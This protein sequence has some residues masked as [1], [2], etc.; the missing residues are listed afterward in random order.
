ML[1]RNNKKSSA[2]ATFI[3]SHVLFGFDQGAQS[4]HFLPLQLIEFSSH[5]MADKVQL[6][7]QL[8]LLISPNKELEVFR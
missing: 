2:F 8:P 5:V 7:S 3:S 4:A 6:F 1:L